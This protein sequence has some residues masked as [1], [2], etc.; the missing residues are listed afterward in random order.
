MRVSG[1]PPPTPTAAPPGGSI[2]AI[3]HHMAFG[4][5]DGP[6]DIGQRGAK[7]KTVTGPSDRESKAPAVKYQPAAA[8]G[9]ADDKPS[10][11]QRSSR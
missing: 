2:D 9:A 4:R 6:D 5:A 3:K 8:D 10:L 11:D 7:G 1:A